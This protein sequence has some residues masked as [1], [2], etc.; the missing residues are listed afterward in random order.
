MR[1]IKSHLTPLVSAVLAAMLTAS[2]NLSQAASS[3]ETVVL[4][5]GLSRSAN[6]MKTMAES[7]NKQGYTVWNINYPSTEHPIEYLANTYLK[8]QLKLCCDDD[9]TIHFVTH[10]MGGILVREFLKNN[11]LPQLGRVVMLGP[12]NQGSEVVDNLKDTG[13][14]Q[15]L[16][17]TAGSQLGTEESSKPNSIGPANFPVGVIAGRKTIN[18]VLSMMI[19]GDDDGKVSVERTKL[20]GMKEQLV[21]PYS[22]TFI[23]NKP[24]VIENTICFLQNGHFCEVDSGST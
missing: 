20:E 16:N 7:L 21:V 5:H 1:Y 9:K 14:F 4:L 8:E 19:P 22:H 17:G 3:D 13:L 24:L 2:S 11:E 10:S 6:S 23:M 15:W 12:P 18:P